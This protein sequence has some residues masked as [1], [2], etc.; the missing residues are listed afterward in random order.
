MTDKP[1]SLP[2]KPQ[3]KQEPWAGAA[4]LHSAR[5]YLGE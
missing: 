5:V 2:K 1:L 4:C 3:S